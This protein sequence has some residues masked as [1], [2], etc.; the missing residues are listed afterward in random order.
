MHLVVS[1]LFFQKDSFDIKQPMKF[2][3][4]LDKEA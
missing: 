3:M 4:Q 1:L 2:D